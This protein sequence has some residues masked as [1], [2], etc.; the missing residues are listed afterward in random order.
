[1]KTSHPKTLHEVAKVNKRSI[2]TF[3]MADG[4]PAPAK[5]MYSF[6]YEVAKIVE[7]R[8]ILKGDAK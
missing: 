8:N 5:A 7:I 1:M 4:K 6:G 2:T 3:T